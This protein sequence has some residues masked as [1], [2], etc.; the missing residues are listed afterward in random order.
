MKRNEVKIKNS[1]A[2]KIHIAIIAKYFNSFNML[3]IFILYSNFL[4]LYIYIEI[5]YCS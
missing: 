1:V 2:T 4:D 3:C 5:N